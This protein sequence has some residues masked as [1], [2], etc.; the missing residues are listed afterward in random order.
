MPGQRSVVCA[1]VKPEQHLYFR[2]DFI[3]DLPAL[4]NFFPL[5]GREVG[6]LVEETLNLAFQ[7]VSPNPVI[8]AL[9]SGE[10]CSL[11]PVYL[12]RSKADYCLKFG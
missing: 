4:E 10:L 11:L 5:I 2:T 9:S 12:M 7:L 3:R 1:G 8:P 6:K